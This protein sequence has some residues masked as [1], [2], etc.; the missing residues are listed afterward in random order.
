MPHFIRIDTLRTPPPGEAFGTQSDLESTY[1]VLVI[2]V[3]RIKR[4][5]CL[6]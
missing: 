2:I 1:V 5:I 6:Y 3:I 4:S